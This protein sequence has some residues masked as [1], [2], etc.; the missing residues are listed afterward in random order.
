MRLWSIHPR[1]L[2]RQGLT[3]LWR[4]GLGAL[5]SIKPGKGYHN[6]PQLDRFKKSNHQELLLQYYMRKVLWEA[7]ARGYKFDASKLKPLRI[8]SSREQIPVTRGQIEFEMKHLYKKMKE[9]SIPQFSKNIKPKNV[10]LN[11]CF[12][13]IEGDI[14]PWEK[15]DGNKSSN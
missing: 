9:R 3:A 2:D 12:Y 11:D 15:T 13:M 6:H 10:I 8:P 1:Y 5:T 14:E 4:E 7:E